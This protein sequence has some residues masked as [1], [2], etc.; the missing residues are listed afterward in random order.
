MR[1]PTKRR[2]LALVP[3]LLLTAPACGDDSG[4]TTVPARK[5]GDEPTSARALAAVVAERLAGQVGEATSARP[6]LDGPRAVGGVGA[7][8]RFAAEDEPSSPVVS[9]SVGPKASA[10]EFTC[11]RLRQD[12]YD[13]CVAADGGVLFWQKETPEEDPGVV[14][15][16]LRKGISTVL[17]FQS[18]PLVTGDPRRLDLRIS[19]KDMFAIARD[20]RVDVTTSAA[21]IR[22]G[23]DLERWTDQP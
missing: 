22:A 2:L 20:P 1:R 14:Y 10:A 5:G 11:A 6:E 18:G 23:E 21:A 3:L 17:L 9:V 7:A 15:V 16:V 19:V 4:A 12:S 8:L 13:G